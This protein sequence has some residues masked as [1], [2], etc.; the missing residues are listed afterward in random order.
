MA[1]SRAGRPTELRSD[2]LRIED[3]LHDRLERRVVDLARQ[4]LEKAVQL[5][6]RPVGGGEELGRVEGARLDSPQRRDL[7]L[8]AAAEPFDLAANL[9]R[10]AAL[11][12]GTEL[13]GL[14]EDPGRDRAGPVPELEAQVGRAVLRLLPVLANHRKPAGERASRL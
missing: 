13:V 7:R 12:A 8:E 11:E 4:V 9:D 6:R 5:L 14:A 2:R 10:V 3:P 1:R